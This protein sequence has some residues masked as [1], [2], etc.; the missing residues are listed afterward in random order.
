MQAL[1][2]A[3]LVGII[4][5]LV[6][7]INQAYIKNQWKWYSTV[8]PFAAAKIWP[9]VLTPVAEH[10]LKPGDIFRECASESGKDHC[11]AM[12][13]LPG[14]S[15]TMG[16]P[17]T[18]QDDK[19]TERPEH[20]VTIAKPFAVSKFLVTFEEWDTCAAYGDCN[21]NISD[22]GWG[23]G[24]QPVINVT[25][26]DAQQYIGWLSRMTGKPYRLLSEAEYEYAARAGMQTAYPWGNDIGKG[27]A[28][29][30]GCGSRWDARQPAPVGSFAPN[31]SACTTW[32]ATC[33]NG[34]R[35]VGTR[36]IA[37]RRKTARHG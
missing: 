12:V 32:S 26:D 1:V 11:P 27:N 13:V 2:D 29:C 14:G 10:A 19:T 37:A 17:A 33:S 25:W 36:T 31:I 7:W 9:H 6:A 8:R 20:Q 23:R 28:D 15:F 5:G 22:D 21:P 16:S 18:E 24:S 4:V 30:N 3:L 34:C 35:I